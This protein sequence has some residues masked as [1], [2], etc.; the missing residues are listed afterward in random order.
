MTEQGYNTYTE[1]QK[2]NENTHAFIRRI[3]KQQVLM[4]A[5]A[6]SVFNES[7]LDRTTL[8]STAVRACHETDSA[9]LARTEMLARQ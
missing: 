4:A 9:W 5:F 2:Q 6:S 8:H 3:R 1:K 7:G